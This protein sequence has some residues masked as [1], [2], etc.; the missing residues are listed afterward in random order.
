MQFSIRAKEAAAAGTTT[1]VE[2]LRH[3]DAQSVMQN[4]QEPSCKDSDV[5]ISAIPWRYKLPS[6]SNRIPKH[7]Q[8]CAVC[9]VKRAKHQLH[10]YNELTGD[11]NSEQKP[12][13]LEIRHRERRSKACQP[14]QGAARRH[15]RY[16]FCQGI[17]AGSAQ[18][19]AENKTTDS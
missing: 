3:R 4:A 19:G 1:S 14:C 2:R 8:T 7:E 10:F 11:S 13:W 18:S 5:N 6:S 16:S 15:P 12:S 17:K 9:S